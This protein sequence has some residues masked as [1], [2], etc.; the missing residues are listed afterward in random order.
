MESLPK[1][2]PPYGKDRALP[3][4]HIEQ[5]KLA[6]GLEIWVL[7]RED[8]PPKVHFVL[9]VRGGLADDPPLQPGFSTLLA[10][11]LKEGTESRDALRIARD[12]QSYGGDMHA[13]AGLDGITVSMSGLASNAA[14]VV[15]LLSEVAVQPG[16]PQHEVDQGKLHALQALIVAQADPDWL[17]RRAIGRAVF[18]GHPYGHVL[19]TSASILAVT[20][21]LLHAEHDRRFRPDEALLV[22]TGRITAE[23][24][25]RMADAVFG[26]W[27][28]EGRP[29]VGVG[30][31]GG[32]V[33]PARVF[34]E[35]DGSVQSA[36]RV[37]R[38]AVAADSPDYFP[39]LMANAVLGGGFGSRLNQNLR[40]DK[41]YTYGAGS[42]MQAERAGG[43][44]VAYANVRNA[45][46]GAAVAQFLRECGQLGDQ[47]VPE[48]ELAQTRHYLAGGYLLLNQQQAQVASTLAD[49]WLAGLP[50]QSLSDYVPGLQAVSASQVQ[51][52][53]RKYFAPK[54]Q[55]IVVVGDEAVLGQLAP[56]GSFEKSSK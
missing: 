27:R 50:P 48:A 36:I 41:G 29:S 23:S 10:D 37:G 16:F 9:A 18:A 28:A 39:L 43:A 31:V 51:A 11:L 17:A 55:S 14:K 24:A 19:P 35:R 30:P 1:D 25:F 49:R 2:L 44:V 42:V 21:D 3:P 15:T 6:N 38:P 56:Y 33:P 40:E 54:E 4:I 20:P 52:A 34:V 45:V 47:P 53:A 26:D 12:L 5:R 8:G 46:T 7:P 22:V 13:D 32:S